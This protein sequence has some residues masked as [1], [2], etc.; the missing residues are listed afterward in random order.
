MKHFAFFCTLFCLNHLVAQQNFQVPWTASDTVSV[1]GDK[2]NVRSQPST[3]GAT[4]TQLVAGDLLRIVETATQ[5]TSMNGL[6][7]PWYKVQSLDR[8]INGFVW[9][10][11][12]SLMPPTT[13]GDTRFVGGVTR[14]VAGTSSENLPGY[15]F[16]IRAIRAGAITAKAGTQIQGDGFVYFQPVEKGARGLKGYSALLQLTL[17]G[18]ACGIPWYDWYVLWNGSQLSSLPVCQSI[19]D[20]DVF[21]HVETYLFPQGRDEYTPGHFGGDDQVYFSI[22]HEEKE[23]REDGTGWDE[24]GWTRARLMRWDGKQWIR[25]KNMGEPRG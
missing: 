5:T 25:P 4:V 20:A 16:E 2:I 22:S 7:L 6:T 3:D 19:S 17:S 23:E 21:S 9:G 8:K 15:T 1:F 12:L 11:L 14:M 10:G 24:N 13:I 18:E